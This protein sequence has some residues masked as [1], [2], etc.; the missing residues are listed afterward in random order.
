[1]DTFGHAHANGFRPP[2]RLGL[3]DVLS[4]SERRIVQEASRLD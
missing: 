3:L 2:H 1:M 4:N